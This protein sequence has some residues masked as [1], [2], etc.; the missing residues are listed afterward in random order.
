[1]DALDLLVE[2]YRRVAILAGDEVHR[3]DD[4]WHGVFP[5]APGMS[6]MPPR[7][8]IPGIRDGDVTRDRRY[9]LPVRLRESGPRAARILRTIRQN[10]TS[11]L[12]RHRA[13]RPRHG[14]VGR[15]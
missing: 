4:T 8:R 11:L 1:M 2:Q 5:P 10:G 13:S 15:I 7:S 12:E 14:P 9:T 3:H 6:G